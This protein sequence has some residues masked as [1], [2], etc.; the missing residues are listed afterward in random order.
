MS[1]PCA[2]LSRLFGLAWLIAALLLASW[3]SGVAYALPPAGTNTVNVTGQVSVTSRTGQESITLTG[4]ATVQL[5]APHTKG[6][7]EANDAELTALNLTGMSLTGLVT[8]SESP[9]VVSNG[10]IRSISDGAFPATSYFNVYAMVAVP[11]SPSPSITL[12]NDVPIVMSVASLNGWPP[13]QAMYT[14]TPNPCVLLQ[15]SLSNPAQICITSA[16]FTLTDPG[17][18][19]VTE[20]AEPVDEHEAV[21]A[22]GAPQHGVGIAIGLA[23]FATVGLVAGY[24]RR[25]LRSNR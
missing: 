20:L 13:Y 2:V 19:G 11:A 18:G 1:E 14:A 10:E 25:K 24:A 17:V 3:S 12:H 9:S 5:A 8:V 16:S 21:S 22:G 15:P 4:T 6:S 7:V 23:L